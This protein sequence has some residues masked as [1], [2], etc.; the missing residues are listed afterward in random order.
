M[1]RPMY[2]GHVTHYFS[3]ASSRVLSVKYLTRARLREH[4]C[5]GSSARNIIYK[6]GFG[7]MA[8]IMSRIKHHALYV[9]PIA[10]HR[11]AD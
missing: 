11:G 10:A 6:Y 8:A 9:M 5:A 2:R 7:E 4:A 3:R 1:S